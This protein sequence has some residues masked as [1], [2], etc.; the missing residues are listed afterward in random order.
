[1]R[2]ALNQAHQGELAA[3][4]VLPVKIQPVGHAGVGMGPAELQPLP[5]PFD[6]KPQHV[7]RIA[8]QPQQACDFTR[9]AIVAVVV[10]GITQALANDGVTFGVR[11]LG[12][13]RP[14]ISVADLN[15]IG[16]QAITS[17]EVIPAVE[18]EL[19]VM[20]VAGQGAAT[21]HATLGQGITFMRTAIIAG[22]QPVLGVEHGNL[23]PLDADH[24]CGAGCEFRGSH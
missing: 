19:P 20:P 11:Q 1:M 12:Q 17:V 21:G 13:I 9:D 24:L 4:L 22:A 15:R 10:K 23:P 6:R 2:H 7:K 14:D 16:S 3:A 18:V 8:T 5:G